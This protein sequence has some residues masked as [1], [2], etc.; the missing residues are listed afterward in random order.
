MFQKGVS[1]NPAGRPKGAKELDRL[2]YLDLQI[3]FREMFDTQAAIKN[4]NERMAFQLQIADKLLAKVQNL[5]SS[6]EESANNARVR[7]EMMAALE[8][9]LKPVDAPAPENGN[10]SQS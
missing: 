6:P 2:N 5:P 8:A 4:P 10:A 1:G 7:Q 3:W 9:D